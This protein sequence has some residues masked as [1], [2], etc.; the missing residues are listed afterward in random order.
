MKKN[1]DMTTGSVWRK[2][3]AYAIPLLLGS[4]FQQ[5][6]S[7]AD[8]WILGWFGNTSAYAAVGTVGTVQN[9]FFNFFYGLTLGA[10]V[11]I[12]QHFGAKKYD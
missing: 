10:A 7:L 4:L 1:I 12:S 2:L 5:L 3:V 9:V 11:L 6:Y 8:T